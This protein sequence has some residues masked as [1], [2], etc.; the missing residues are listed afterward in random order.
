MTTGGLAAVK[1]TMQLT[2][3]GISTE[4]MWSSSRVVYTPMATK[5]KRA[6]RAKKKKAAKKRKVRRAPKRRPAKKKRRAKK[7]RP[8]KRKRSGARKSASGLSLRERKVKGL[9][10]RNS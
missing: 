4:D 8:A 10:S 5:K 3:F 9:I 1:E 2:R 6:K 7:R